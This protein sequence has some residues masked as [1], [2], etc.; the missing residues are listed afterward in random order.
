MSERETNI[1]ITER[2][3]REEFFILKVQYASEI[4]Y[5]LRTDLNLI[6]FF[7]LYYICID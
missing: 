7:I 4:P 1:E 3:F 2:I 5:L 6:V